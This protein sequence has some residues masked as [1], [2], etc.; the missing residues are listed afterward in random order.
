[1]ERDTGR[2]GCGQTKV[3]ERT[4]P[5]HTLIS[6]SWS[7]ELCGSILLLFKLAH[8]RQLHVPVCPSVGP[9]PL[10]SPT[11]H[12]FPTSSSTATF[13]PENC[14]WFPVFSMFSSP[15]SG[16]RQCTWPRQHGESLLSDRHRAAFGP[17]TSPWTSCSAQ[18]RKW[19]LLP[20]QQ[21]HQ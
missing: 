17:G 5:G 19:Q 15:G 11:L 20:G 2:R 4:N 1:M 18:D 3:S 12:L 21:A 7:R 13:S 16:R 14:F 10:L 9:S 6:D 8:L